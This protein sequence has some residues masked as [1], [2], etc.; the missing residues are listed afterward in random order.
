MIFTIFFIGTKGK[1]SQYGLSEKN[2]F[3]IKSGK[4]FKLF[5]LEE[6]KQKYDFHILSKSNTKNN[7]GNYGPW[8]FWALE[9]RARSLQCLARKAFGPRRN[10]QNTYV[11]QYKI[12]TFN[13]WTSA[14]QP[15]SSKNPFFLCIKRLQLSSINLLCTYK[16]RHKIIL[17]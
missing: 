13:S 6:S 12:G 3:A 11:G 2:I 1:S 4:E 16:N 17:F 7:G 10:C 8:P 9:S 14:I 15:S 5:L